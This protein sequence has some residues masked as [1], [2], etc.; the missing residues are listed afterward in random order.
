MRLAGESL[1]QKQMMD[2]ERGKLFPRLRRVVL[3]DVGDLTWTLGHSTLEIFDIELGKQLPMA[4]LGI[5]TVR[6]VCQ[7][8]RGGPLTLPADHYIKPNTPISSFTYHLRMPGARGWSPSPP[9]LVIGCVN[10]YIFKTVHTVK[11]QHLDDPSTRSLVERCVEDLLP[12]FAQFESKLSVFS[13]NGDEPVL[14]R[15]DPVDIAST[16]IEIYDF[17]R[18]EK[19]DS[20][21]PGDITPVQ[22]ALDRRLGPWSGRVTI[23]NREDCPACPACGYDRKAE[24]Y[25]EEQE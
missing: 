1:S 5:P 9:P 6:H 7:S 11:E 25:D 15:L 16:A 23:R 14:R 17:I 4:L 19:S 10:R 20:K 12:I 13:M 8:L 21:D 22:L 2:G 18:C 24:Y 3:G